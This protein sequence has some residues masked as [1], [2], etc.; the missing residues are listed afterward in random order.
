MAKRFVDTRP[1]R[2]L[3]LALCAV[4]PPLVAFGA[5]AMFLSTLTRWLMFNGAVIVSSW[6]GGLEA[7]IASTI[8]SAGLVWWF[9]AP[10]ERSLGAADPRYLLT[11]TIFL[12][13]GTAV[14]LLHENLRRA[15][16]ALGATTYELEEAQRLAHIGSWTWDL[17]TSTGWWSPEL[18]RIHRRDPAL[19]LPGP[20][21][22]RHFFTP[23]SA[24]A[25]RAA[26]EKMM[27]DGT[28]FELELEAVFP[29]GASCWVATH[30]EAVRD[31]SGKLVGLRGT[32]Q[33]IT[34][35]KTL[36]RLKEEWTSV[37]AHDLR[38]PIGVITMSA[39]MLP[40]PHPGDVTKPESASVYHIRSAARSLNRMVSDLLDMSRLEAH[41]L[42][43]ERG[44]HDPA[45]LV[46]ETLEHLR[47][48]TPQ[49]DVSVSTEGALHPVYVDRDRFE[50]ILGNVVSNAVKYGDRKSGIRIH[51]A[52][53]GDDVKFGVA[54]RGKG[55]PK[56]ELS[57]IFTRF[58]RTAGTHGSGVSGLGLG[59][60]IAR[61]LVEAHGGRMWAESVPGDT[62]TFN[63]SLPCHDRAEA[64]A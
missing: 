49:S 24:A 52:Q 3:R 47:H 38:Q 54:N 5:E 32:S 31:K 7:G 59:L 46:H 34:R 15:R 44:W 12:A 17:R 39:E 21:E 28:P 40:D 23:E 60:Y 20:D 51:L 53:M 19:P 35:L 30:G 22:L 14:S 43:L 25:I 63:F 56:D 4:L 1:G 18:Y 41:R 45:R 2:A 8:L 11:V 42:S 37:V 33:D 62:T 61:G 36:E 16:R 10:P 6:L 29:D 57:R 55:I 13:I 26:V 9:L 27:R 64:A 48:L 58:G 50:Q